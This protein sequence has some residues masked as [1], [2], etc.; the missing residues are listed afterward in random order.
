MKSDD[1]DGCLHPDYCSAGSRRTIATLT[2]PAGLA[3]PDREHLADLLSHYACE[4]LKG[5]H[6]NTE[7][8]VFYERVTGLGPALVMTT[9][10]R[11]EAYRT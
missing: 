2:M 10:D 8:V 11:R 9:E 1:H 3:K 6:V 5:E 7:T 4:L